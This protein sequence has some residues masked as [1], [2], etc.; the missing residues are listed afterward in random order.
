VTTTLTRLNEHIKTMKLTEYKNGIFFFFGFDEYDNFI[1]KVLQP[2][3][4]YS[5]FFYS[6]SDKFET[7]LILP[8][9][10]DKYG[11]IT[12]I[13]G[14]ICYIYTFTK[15]LFVK[16]KTIDGNLQ[17][18]QRKGGQS[19]L[20]ISRLA[21]ETRDNYITRVTDSI[22]SI[23]SIDDYDKYVHWC[24]GGDEMRNKLLTNKKLLVDLKDGKF[25]N[26]TNRTIESNK[27]I[28]YL[29]KK[30][31]YNKLYEEIELFLDTDIDMLSFDFHSRCDPTTK[32]YLGFDG[33][34]LPK[35]GRLSDFEFI[36]V[37]Y[38]SYETE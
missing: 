8:Y 21:E 14:D 30:D 6:C 16:Y 5:G 35:T 24:F 29:D 1:T 2:Q 9:F 38:Y 19:A 32:Y 28:T 11:S 37:K 25:L 20:R 17:K 23:R 22:N 7:D 13:N 10:E 36:G 15:G 31:D 3:I 34:P 33:L 4:S 27:W 18:R 26:F 12:F